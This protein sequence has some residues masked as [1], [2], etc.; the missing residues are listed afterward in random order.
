MELSK[1]QTLQVLNI[2]FNPPTSEESVKISKHEDASIAPR[3]KKKTDFLT[4]GYLFS[5]YANPWHAFKMFL[6]F[7]TSYPVLRNDILKSGFLFSNYVKAGKTL[8]ARNGNRNF[9]NSIPFL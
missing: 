2:L 9:A 3:V 8:T 4:S 5:K 7:A 6:D 1:Y